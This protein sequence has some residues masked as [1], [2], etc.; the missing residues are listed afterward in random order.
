MKSI[1]RQA[2]AMYDLKQFCCYGI[3]D[4]WFSLD[5]RKLREKPA[6][7]GIYIHNGKKI[8]IK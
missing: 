2:F 7:R 8:I 6:Q 1:G 4:A 3:E 5:G